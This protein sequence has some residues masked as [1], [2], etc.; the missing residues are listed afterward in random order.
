MAVAGY[1]AY[2]LGGEN[3]EQST[4][5]PGGANG[6]SWKTGMGGA[7]R[8]PVRVAQHAAAAAVDYWRR[9]RSA[10]TTIGREAV[11]F[12]AGTAL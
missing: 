3:G 8:S 1:Y 6:E 7:L 2:S 5:K 9:W 11:Y 4:T 10:G 12:R